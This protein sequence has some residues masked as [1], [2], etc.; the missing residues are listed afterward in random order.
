MTRLFTLAYGLFGAFAALAIIVLALTL[1]APPHSA[2]QTAL[3]MAIRQDTPPAGQ[4]TSTTTA[5]FARAART[6]R[7]FDPAQAARDL[8]TSHLTPQGNVHRLW[9]S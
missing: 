3:A 2:D 5:Q 1:L 7:S 6:D 8:A 4:L 9:Y